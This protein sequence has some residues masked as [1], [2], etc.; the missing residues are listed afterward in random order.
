MSIK[1]ITSSS[2]ITTSTRV[3]QVSY[4]E[5][6]SPIYSTANNGTTSLDFYTL[7]SNMIPGIFVSCSSAITTISNTYVKSIRSIRPPDTVL[8]L[9][10]TTVS[11]ASLQNNSGIITPDAGSGYLSYPT[12][13]SSSGSYIFPAGNYRLSY[14]GGAW[15]DQINRQNSSGTAGLWTTRTYLVT[16]PTGTSNTSFTPIQLLTSAGINPGSDIGPFLTDLQVITSSSG[17]YF[18]FAHPGG[19]LGLCGCDDDNWDTQSISTTYGGPAFRLTL[20]S[21]NTAYRVLLSSA[22]LS[23]I[24]TGSTVNFYGQVID[25]DKSNTGFTALTDTL[26]IEP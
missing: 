10:T 1:N 9:S 4:T 3:L 18:D 12:W 25:L 13:I 20:Y 15:T 6:S 16:N 11:L 21:T 22:I 17:Q 5:S 23:S 8:T 7:S 14:V 2:A 19:A 26:E 24:T